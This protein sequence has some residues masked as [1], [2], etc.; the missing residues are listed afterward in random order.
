M[1][2]VAHMAVATGDERGVISCGQPIAVH[3]DANLGPLSFSCDGS[4]A[5]QIWG[6]GAALGRHLINTGLPDRPEVVEVGSGT[7]VAGLGAAI[8]GASRVVLTDLPD[9]VGRLE[10]QIE[11]NQTVLAGS[12]VSAAALAWGSASAAAAVCDSGVDLVLAADVLYSGEAEVQASLR[13][14]LVALAKPRDATILHAYE[15]RWPEIVQ[16]WRDGIA[17]SGLRVVS[18]IV[19]DAPW[20]APD[21]EY[22]GFRERRLVLEELKLTEEC[23]YS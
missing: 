9:V 12:D 17:S 23:L 6:A 15:E 2:L 4:I 8:A 11:R 1:S 10:K 22:S 13:A 21:G 16:M 14:T 7:G 19:L 18:E 20:M 5:G 3:G